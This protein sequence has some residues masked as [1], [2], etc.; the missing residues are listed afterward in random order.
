VPRVTAVNGLRLVAS[1]LRWTTAL[2]LAGH[3]ALGA[4]VAKPLLA[5]HYAAI[6]LGPDVV[7]V[8]GTIEIAAAVAVLARPS[9][10]LLALVAA[11]KLASESLFL[12]A[13]APA[14][15]FIERGGSYA[16]PIALAVI[17]AHQRRG[18][19]AARGIS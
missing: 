6:G 8:I 19:R 17:L 1:T 18:L 11:W 14:W 2:L 7:P 15:E 10:L 12:L 4:F 9:V 3:G 13:G 16:A 5:E